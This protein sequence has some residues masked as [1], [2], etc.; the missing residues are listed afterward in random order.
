[1]QVNIVVFWVVTAFQLQVNF[2]VTN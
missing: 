1:L 2:S